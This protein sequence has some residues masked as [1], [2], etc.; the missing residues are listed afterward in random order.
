VGWAGLF[1]P[2]WFKLI[3]ILAFLALFYHAWVGIRDLW[4]D[5]IK[6]LGLRLVLHTLTALW[7]IACA[8]YAVM[9]IWRV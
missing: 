2:M 8:F 7:L 9:I 4:M 1:A 5:Y 3:S 6:P